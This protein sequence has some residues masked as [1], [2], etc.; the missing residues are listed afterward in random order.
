M[1]LLLLDLDLEIFEERR[2]KS[3][4]IYYDAINYKDFVNNQQREKKMLISKTIC[5]DNIYLYVKY[6][7]III[8]KKQISHL[9]LFSSKVRN[10]WEKEE[11]EKLKKKKMIIF[12]LFQ[13]KNKKKR[14]EE[15]RRRKHKQKKFKNVLFCSDIKA[16]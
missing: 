4:Y 14:K 12:D 16:Y 8:N 11:E 9:F 15:K 6:G 13:F 7:T 1:L 2:E 3:Q 5:I 10:S